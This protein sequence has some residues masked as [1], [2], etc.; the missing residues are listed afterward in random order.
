[1]S[2]INLDFGRQGEETAAKYLANLGFKILE[3]SYRCPMGELDIIASEGGALVFVEVKARSTGAFGGALLAV[4]RR[5][6]EKIIKTALSYIKSRGMKP[7]SIRF[8]V[9]AIQASSPPNLV[10]NAFTPSRYAY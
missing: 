5:K 8:D 10:R 9:I 7:E 1:M 2:P 6:Q 4:N 3:R